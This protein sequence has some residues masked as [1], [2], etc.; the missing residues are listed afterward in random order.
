MSDDLRIADRMLP[1]PDGI[2]QEYW[3]GLQRGELRLQHCPACS[4]LQFYPRALC[5]HCAGDVEWVTASGHGTVHTF[6]VVRANPAEPFR[7]L[8]PY[9]LAIVR[10][11]EG[12]QM[13]TNIIGCPPDDVRI[14]MPVELAPVSVG[15]VA[16]PFWTPRTDR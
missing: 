5:A 4:R 14:G 12:P 15:D 16:L 11:D 8:V 3:D 9:V 7:S 10:L 13:M 2:S 1:Q 6:T